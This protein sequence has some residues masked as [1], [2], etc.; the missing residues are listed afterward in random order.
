MSRHKVDPNERSRVLDSL[1]HLSRILQKLATAANTANVV[2]PRIT[3]D[4]QPDEVSTRLLEL[5]A[6][7]N[8]LSEQAN[9]LKS[10]PSLQDD[11]S[12]DALCKL[13]I[14]LN[15]QIVCDSEFLHLWLRY[16][17][18]YRDQHS[19]GFQRLTKFPPPSERELLS[20]G[21]SLERAATKTLKTMVKLAKHYDISKQ[22]CEQ[23]LQTRD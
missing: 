17:E 2:V 21:K 4:L 3:L 1:V 9:D 22:D 10:W 19:I 15:E 20:A 12:V 13:L 16:V 23:G 6:E 14:L 18:Q 8:Q 11:Y 7:V 5:M